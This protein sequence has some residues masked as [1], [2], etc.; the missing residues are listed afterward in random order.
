MKLIKDKKLPPWALFC[1]KDLSSA[2]NKAYVPKNCA[3]IAE[4]AMLLHPMKTPLGWTG[5]LIAK[6]S[7]SNQVRDFVDSHG[8]IIRLTVPHIYTKVVAEEDVTLS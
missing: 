3:L 2:E 4:D 5:L 7:A 6:E 8:E 1:F